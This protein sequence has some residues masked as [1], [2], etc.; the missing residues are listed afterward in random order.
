[1]SE[2]TNAT[3]QGI[4]GDQLELLLNGKL[5]LSDPVTGASIPMKLELPGGRQ[6]YDLAIA[7]G[8]SP[9]AD[10]GPREYHVTPAVAYEVACQVLGRPHVR[11]VGPRGT[12]PHPRVIEVDF[13]NVRGFLHLSASGLARFEEAFAKFTAGVPFRASYGVLTTCSHVPFR[14]L[15]NALAECWAIA[16]DSSSYLTIDQ[17]GPQRPARKAALAM[18]SA[19]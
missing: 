19:E 1:M 17:A 15:D 7:R 5:R 4:D 2:R 6:Q 13:A 16:S 10:S 8:Y 14:Q 3:W 9:W 18:A 11:T 12:H